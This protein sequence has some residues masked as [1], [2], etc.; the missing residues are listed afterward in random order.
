MGSSD[1]RPH[2][3]CRPYVTNPRAK[4]NST[5]NIIQN[6]GLEPRPVVFQPSFNF[7]RGCANSKDWSRWSLA[8]VFT[9]VVSNV[10]GEG[11]GHV[12]KLYLSLIPVDYK[13]LNFMLMAKT[14]INVIILF[15]PSAS[16][17]MWCGLEWAMKGTKYISSLEKLNQNIQFL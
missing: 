5:E 9:R 10:A 3:A 15:L 11:R 16:L 14:S 8:L 13:Q 4:G 6:E 12:N 1:C 7:P 2:V 17:G